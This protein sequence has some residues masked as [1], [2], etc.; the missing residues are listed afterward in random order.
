[1]GRKN[2]YKVWQERVKHFVY[3]STTGRTPVKRKVVRAT[4]KFPK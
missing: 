4:A 3:K 2:F 1:M